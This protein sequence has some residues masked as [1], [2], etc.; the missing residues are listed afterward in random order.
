MSCKSICDANKYEARI[1]ELKEQLE[2]LE[3]TGLDFLHGVDGRNDEWRFRRALEA[4]REVLSK[5]T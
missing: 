1:A 2:E 4:T 3:R 5:D